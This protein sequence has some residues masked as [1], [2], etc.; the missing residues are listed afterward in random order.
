VR[1]AEVSIR[2]PV[3]AAML[4]LG[5]VVLG[6]VSLA[7]LEMKL[8]PDIDFPFATVTTEL[9]G[10][11]PETVEREVTDVLEEQI[12]AIEGIRHLH[13]TS[14]Q[15]LS[16]IHAEFGLQYDVDVKAQ[17][18][19]D[20]VAAARARLPV[21]AE[22][23]LVEKFDLSAVGFLTIV[24]GGP[25]GRRELS[26][27]AEHD[28]KER[29]ERIPGVGGIRITGAREREVRIW[30][31]PLRLSGYGLAIED[32]AD[33]LRRE[34]AELASG[35]IEGARREWSVT[36]QGKARSVDEFG[37]IVVA[38][39]AGRLI[40]L[41]D[42]A[43]VEDG[44]AEERS[45]ARL[46][47]Q[48]G[49]ALE[50]QQQSGSDL[51]AAT[52]LIREELE[53]I[54]AQAP[55]G[56]EVTVLRDYARIIEEQITSIL[57]DMLLAAA[58]V[59][60]VVL[61]FLRDGRSTLIASLAIPASV[62]A[63]FTLLHAFDLSLNNMTLMAL[64][65]S[66]G[67]VID[68][69]IVVLEA[70]FRKVE[71]GAG[72]VAAALDG[73]RE[74]GLA[75]I[76]TTLA[77]CAVFLPIRFMTSTM[78]RYF[79]EFGV[80]VTVAV[81]IS[82]LVALTLTPMLAS[83]WLHRSPEQPPALP[84]RGR[85]PGR[86]L[87]RALSALER[88]YARLLRLALSHRLA[89]LLLAGVTV[90]SGCFVRST[91]P[92]NYFTR[93]DM[94]EAQVD[95]KHPIG[96]PLAVT[97]RTMRDVEAA[98][99]RHPEVRT[100][101]GAAGNEVQH[102]PH[103][104]R[105]NAML[106]PKA[107]RERPIDA[108]FEELRALVAAAVPPGVEVS[109]GHP[110]YASTSGDGW[111]SIQYGI[112]GPE[113]GEL[114]RLASALRAKLEAHPG[115]VDV[116][117]SH[118]TG[119]PQVTLEVDRARAADA[120]VSAVALGRTLRTLLAGEK[121]GSFEDGGNRHDVRVQV[122]PE[123]RDDPG[124]LDLIRIRSLRGELV[125]ISA[126]AAVRVES[127]PVQVRRHNRARM[128]RLYANTAPGFS[129]DLAVAQL[130][131]WSDEIGIAPPYALVPG[132]EAESQAEAGA[133]IAFAMGLGMLAIYMIL[134]SLF[135]SL[136]HP[137]TIMTSAPLS[138][139]G[140]F[141]A[142]KVAGQSLDVMGMMGL[143][144]LMGLVMKNGILLVDYTNQ[145]RERGMARDEAILRAGPVRMRPVLMTSAA[146]IF[147]LLPL[148]LSNA[149]GAEFRAPMAII[150]IGG[151]VT[152]TLLTLVVVPV[153][154]A[155]VDAATARA[156]GAWGRLTPRGRSPARSAGRDPRAAAGAPRA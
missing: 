67:L 40:Q 122:L 138:F 30:L 56:V 20:K 135:D 143:L 131:A 113:L 34:N 128:I 91:L 16:R 18:L 145:L 84:F 124:K 11:S 148:A 38:E 149:T 92:V 123:Y 69:A 36:T 87:E 97:A 43:A 9:R 53:A 115:F 136:A 107:E 60:G 65:L 114:E 75:V 98:L 13:S 19:R 108:T 109:V 25:V 35:R 12:N 23:P 119:R 126:A 62:I 26:D 27:F 78:G 106:A 5:L 116:R 125:P 2:R 121:V 89:T 88:G 57:V 134:A 66:V 150:V 85:S 8:E 103:K 93:D 3:F 110:E 50:V 45:V 147:G 55:P 118:E 61:V 15:G 94:S 22:A 130:E 10:A 132:G 80:T 33:T 73:T 1:L 139:V 28:V 102:E 37:A 77:V 133:D 71:E 82:S 140:G 21:D 74:V 79:Y 46:D 54:R 154:Y 152:S 49:V 72:P 95:A 142:L 129:L 111:S 100:V 51:V 127:G 151:L 146:L 48:P 29:L 70:I 144:V 156:R 63:S 7:R 155:L 81:A 141:F 137:L 58:L 117:S 6:L 4:N 31:D 64:S 120:G 14:E 101:F 105:L 44:M 96:T 99:A 17:E 52:R 47:G 59:M 41:R 39:R 153:F 42:V 104:L 83:R 32:V 86:F 68:D 76:S 90:A 24:L 112:E